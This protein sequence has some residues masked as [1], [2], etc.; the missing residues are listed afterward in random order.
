MQLVFHFGPESGPLQAA[1]H[2]VAHLA[3]LGHA[4]DLQAIRDVVVDRL[5]KGIGPLENHA[6]APPQIGHVHAAHVFVIQQNPAFHAR[7]FDRIVDAVQIPQEGRLAASRRPDQRRHFALQHV[8]RDIVQRLKLTVIEIDV[9]GPQFG[10]RCGC[11]RGHG[12]PLSVLDGLRLRSVLGCAAHKILEISHV[13][14]TLPWRGPAGPGCWR[15]GLRRLGPGP[16]PRLA[17]ANRRR[18]IRLESIS[19]PGG[20]PSVG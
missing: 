20:K 14:R 5:R 6:H 9:G 7:V 8:E 10:T 18:P 11:G 3:P 1:L 4:V 13:E 15:S 16:R 2:P 12:G 19:L 17:G